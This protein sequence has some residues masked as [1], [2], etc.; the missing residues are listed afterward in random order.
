M[1]DTDVLIDVDRG[2]E[3]LPDFPCFISVIT[4]YEFIRGKVDPVRSK[5][6]LEEICITIPLSN[7]VI[8][9]ASLIWREL[10]RKGQVMEE[11]D[12]LIGV[13][14]IVSGLPLWTRNRK[15]FSKLERY[16]LVFWEYG[17]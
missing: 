2:R 11:R 10:R 1:L 9:R 5:E 17:L 6:L 13:T 16:G 14:S 4:L 15:H 3:E 7:E 12:L 8:K